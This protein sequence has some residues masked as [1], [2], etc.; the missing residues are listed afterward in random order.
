MG[1]LDNLRERWNNWVNPSQQPTNNQANQRDQVHDRIEQEGSGGIS[2]SS[3]GGQT[4]T[5]AQ[6]L[7]LRE[8]L[9]RGIWRREEEAR[10]RRDS[11]RELGDRQKQDQ[12]QRQ[13]AEAG[14]RKS[15]RER[16]AE[17][18][19]EQGITETERSQTLEQGIER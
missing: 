15:A 2:P 13:K 1:F 16:L 10:A 19:A 17:I 8:A 5:K 4:H 11:K 3:S 18:R 12:A 14:E 6:E 7:E 9:G